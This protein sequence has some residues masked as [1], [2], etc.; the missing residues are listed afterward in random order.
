M[1]RTV[2]ARP[3]RFGVDVRNA[4]NRSY[5]DFLSRYKSFTY[6]PGVNLIFKA[7]AGDF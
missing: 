4:T 3:I 2:R 6:G 1:E 7:T 5:T